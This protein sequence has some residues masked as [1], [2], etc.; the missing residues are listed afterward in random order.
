MAGAA[1]E[2]MAALAGDDDS[3]EFPGFVA[4]L[5]ALYARSRVVCCPIRVG[6]GTRIKLIEAAAFGKPIVATAVAAEGLGLEPDRDFLLRD[7]SAQLADACVTALTDDDVAERLAVAR[8][9][10]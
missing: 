4:D 6:G 9:R 5:N 7:T 1:S 2:P 10:G 8:A 3:I